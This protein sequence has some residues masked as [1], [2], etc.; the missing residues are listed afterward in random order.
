MPTPRQK[1]T[2]LVAEGLTLYPSSMRGLAAA[3][4]RSP[5]RKL[6]PEAGRKFAAWVKIAHPA[7][8]AAAE[9]KAGGTGLA[10][11]GQDTAPTATAPPQGA[12]ERFVST[13][14]QLAPVYIQARAQKE[15][16]D[17]QMDRARAGL[18]PLRPTD[19]APAV[20][21]SVDPSMY[22]PQLEAL[23]PWLLYGGIAVAGLVLFRMFGGSRGRR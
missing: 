11:L 8:F 7:L 13:I 6:S 21:L 20:Q 5:R 14:T 10:G 3:G 16:L 12:L 1:L 19:Y 17:V 22:S 2:E 4:A 18:P 9:R 23:K 15:L